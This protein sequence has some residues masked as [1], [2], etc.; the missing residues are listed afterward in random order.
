MLTGHGVEPVSKGGGNDIDHL[1]FDRI[2]GHASGI[3]RRSAWRGLGGGALAAALLWGT[4]RRVVAHSAEDVA[5]DAVEAVNQT[6]E[7]GDPSGFD[8]I[9]SS[10]VKVH[11][12]HVS[13]AFLNPPSNDL[14]GLTAALEETRSVCTDA[15]MVVDDLIAGGNKAAG[16][17]TFRATPDA[18]AFGLPEQPAEPLEPL[19][20]GGVISGVFL[21]SGVTEF[22]CYS[23][24]GYGQ[25]PPGLLRPDGHAVRADVRIDHRRHGRDGPV[26][27]GSHAP[28]AWRS[29]TV[30]RLG[31][32]IAR[33]VL[34]RP[35]RHSSVMRSS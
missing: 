18:A 12:L 14:A 13:L 19:E 15:E 27:L 3:S 9:V 32:A 17:F 34:A 22:W 28:V 11:P 29:T 6:L 23:G 5:R 31:V 25:P 7:T 2:A 33:L 16:R 20:I 30:M 1:K 24:V 8:A 26:H 35:V 4:G 21:D 10:D